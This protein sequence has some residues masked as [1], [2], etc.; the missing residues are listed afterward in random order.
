MPIFTSSWNLNQSIA[1]DT[2]NRAL[3]L[4]LHISLE[5]LVHKVVDDG[6]SAVYPIAETDEV[7]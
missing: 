2:D 7:I 1:P 5:T 6:S 4:I 3:L